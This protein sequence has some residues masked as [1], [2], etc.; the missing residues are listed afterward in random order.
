MGAIAATFLCLVLSV[1]DGDGPFRCA[2][3]VKLRAAGVQA[4]DYE[5]AEPCRQH[6]A[7]Y[8]C[9]DDLALDGKQRA[10][11]LLVGKTLTC[12]NLGRS[13]QRVVADCRLPDGRNMSCA[14]IRAGAGVEWTAYWRRY[15][16][17]ACS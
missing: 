4:A 10:A 6:R 7:G 11:R 5:K 14:L 12:R 9:D 13:W 1:H 17:G 3:G 15:R 2:S 16:M 8:L